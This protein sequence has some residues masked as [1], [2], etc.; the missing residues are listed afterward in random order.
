MDYSQRFKTAVFGG[1]NKDDVVAYI[2]ELAR[3]RE[4]FRAECD[5]LRTRCAEL[6]GTLEKQSAR[7]TNLEEAETRASRLMARTEELEKR[8]AGI[9]EEGL[10][11]RAEQAEAQLENTR[12]ALVKEAEEKAA[13]ASMA[14][15]LAREHEEDD[16]RLLQRFDEERESMQ[17]RFNGIAEDYERLIAELQ[18]ERS[19]AEGLL[20][21]VAA[22]GKSFAKFIREEASRF[23]GVDDNDDSDDS[24]D[25]R[26]SE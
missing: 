3:E 7:L 24:D 21:E 5:E 15:S 17:R 6:D 16:K 14:E 22:L 9:D 13:L 12:A 4:A 19:R 23:L 1:F 8:L 11:A 25:M 2:E 18:G 26:D 10:R 20:G